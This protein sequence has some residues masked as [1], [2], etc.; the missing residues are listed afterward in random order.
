[1]PLVAGSDRVPPSLFGSHHGVALASAAS[2]LGSPA[3]PADLAGPSLAAVRLASRRDMSDMA[4]ADL[5]TA[6]ST[7]EYPADVTRIQRNT[8]QPCP[9]NARY[10]PIAGC[11][12]SDPGHSRWTVG[13]AQP[14]RSVL[15]SFFS[16]VRC[17]FRRRRAGSSGSHPTAPARLRTPGRRRG[18][19]ARQIRR[20][21]NPCMRG[22]ALRTGTAGDAKLNPLPEAK[23]SHLSHAA[24]PGAPDLPLKI[25][26][27]SPV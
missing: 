3:A 8:H 13:C 27:L 15:G 19:R 25:H 21:S 1:M 20:S 23:P 12:R 14:P 4:V 6:A 22:G 26:G 5:I 24:A 17:G 10:I 9:H 16:A 7:A 18:A 11:S 2:L